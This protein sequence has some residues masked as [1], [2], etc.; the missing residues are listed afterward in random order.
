MS[1][2]SKFLSAKK[3]VIDDRLVD[4]KALVVDKKLKR[5]SLDL[6]EDLHKKLKLAAL[7]KGVSMRDLSIEALHKFLDV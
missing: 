7:N 1:G 3:P 6:D 4:A 5:L 2:S